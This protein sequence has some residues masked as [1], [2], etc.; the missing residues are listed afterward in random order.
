MFEITFCFSVFSNK[1]HKIDWI[2]KN[3][4][5]LICW[6]HITLS[7]PK[8]KSVK[9]LMYIHFFYNLN[10]CCLDYVLIYFANTVAFRCETD[11]WMAS[12]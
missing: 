9:C 3:K 7:G 10:V 2:E 11:M 12:E 5:W 8:Y 1:K 4:G 6:K